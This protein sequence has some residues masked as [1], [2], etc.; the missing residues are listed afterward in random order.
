[1]LDFELTFEL[2]RG[3]AVVRHVIFVPAVPVERQLDTVNC[4]FLQETDPQVT[5]F[6]HQ[7]IVVVRTDFDEMVGPEHD[8]ATDWM[9]HAV[10]PLDNVF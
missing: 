3:H 6:V 8:P 5:I 7:E 4:V 10:P 1:M 9:F 2:A